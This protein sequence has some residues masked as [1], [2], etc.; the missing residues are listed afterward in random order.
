MASFG[1]TQKWCPWA[2]RTPAG[3]WPDAPFN[4]T[5]SPKLLW[6]TTEG[7]SASGA[8]RTYQ[9]NG[10]APHFT[11]D[12]YSG[13]LHQHY[14]IDS[15]STTLADGEHSVNRQATIQVEIV[16]TC[17]RSASWAGAASRWYVGNWTDQAYRNLARLAHWIEQQCGVPRHSSVKWDDYPASITTVR[18]SWPAYAAT[19][20]HL[21]HM[22]A[23]WNSHGDPGRIDLPRLFA[24]MADL[25]PKPTSPLEED[26]PMR[27]DP[28]YST[29]SSVKSQPLNNGEWTRVAMSDS[30]VSLNSTKITPCLFA[31]DAAL[32]LDG[33]PA[34]HQVQVRSYT[35]QAGEGDTHT[36]ASPAREFIATEGQTLIGWSQVAQELEAGEYLRVEVLV[37]VDGAVVTKAQSKALYWKEAAA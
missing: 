2:T 32:Y 6:H 15:R 16:G 13:E 19:S 17:D 9:A 11:I 3:R 23:P 37:Y 22:H 33:I 21:G 7:A 4:S 29:T 20:G 1:L 8:I 30:N 14:P 31:Y 36:G 5:A 28:F 12:P 34:G 25:D 10:Y 18:L 26:L 27:R 35:C 24:F